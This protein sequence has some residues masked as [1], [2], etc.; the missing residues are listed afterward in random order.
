LRLENGGE[1]VNG[2][3][4]EYLLQSSIDWHRSVPHTPQQNGV[5]ECKNRT[6]VKMARC[7]LQAKYQP[8]HLWD[9]EIYHENYLL[10]HILTRVVPSMTPV[11]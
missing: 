7:I 10:N 1:Y 4:E 9:E 6:L 11:E 3:F 8:L 2:P 5:A